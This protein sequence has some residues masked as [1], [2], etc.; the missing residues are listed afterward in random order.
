MRVQK[1]LRGENG[2]MLLQI[3]EDFFNAKGVSLSGASGSGKTTFLRMLAG[4]TTPD[5]GYISVDGEVWFDSEARINLPPEKRGI[6]YVF[7]EYNLFPNMTVKENLRFALD[8]NV[9]RDFLEELIERTELAELS[10]IKPHALSGGQKQ[11]VALVR[12]LL[13]KP[14]LVLLDEALSALDAK[15]RTRLQKMIALLQATYHFKLFV[16]SHDSSELCTLSDE[17]LLLERG[18]VAQ[19][20]APHDLLTLSK[21]NTSFTAEIVALKRCDMI[22]IA[23]LKIGNVLSKVSLTHEEGELLRVSDHMIAS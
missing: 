16:V 4:L 8:K 5:S 23:T 15:M 9:S 20:G 11:R 22:W 3:E 17:L 1:K 2:A 12:A 19:R 13:R 18:T 21:N 10:N 6:G 7:Q 14:K